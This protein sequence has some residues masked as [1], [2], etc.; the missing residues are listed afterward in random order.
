MGE[1]KTTRRK[2]GRRDFLKS[3]VGVLALPHVVPASAAGRAGHVPPSE[4]V[5][6][7]FIGVGGRGTSELKAFIRNSD[8]QILAV[9]DPF[10]DRRE[11][12][13]SLVESYCDE[14][15]SQ[16]G[17]YKGCAA[18]NDFRDVL[19]RNDIDAVDIATQD[20]WHIP[21]AIAAVRAKKHLQIAKP[22]WLCIAEQRKLCEAVNENDV[23][24]QFGT[25]QRHGWTFKQAVELVHSE[26]IGKLHT[27][28]VGS[29]AG[30]ELENQPTMSIP[31]GFD[32]DLWLGPAPFK[33]YTEKRCIIPWWYHISDYT[34]S[35]FVAGWG[36]HHLDIAQWGNKADR[37]GP[38][39]I[40]GTGIFPKRGICDTALAWDL[41]LKYANGVELIYTDERTDQ[42]NRSSPDREKCERGVL[43][44]GTEGWVFVNR[45]RI[46]A[47]PTNLLG[48]RKKEWNIPY[49]PQEGIRNLLDC[50][51]T[52]RKAICDV[53]TAHRTT[54]VCHLS[55]ICLLLGRKLK[56]DPKIEQFI[57][58]EEANKLLHRT[59]RSPWTL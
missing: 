54:T 7:A 16:K 1:S 3:A 9:C 10:P 59:M 38:V 8:V 30:V 50:I 35:G 22:L 11:E 58:D 43:F 14:N 31:E 45:S 57:D 23:V 47:Q 44:E 40:E 26:R 18:Y 13:K 5:T 52:R 55:R 48:Y 49:V 27:I 56:W 6:M 25:Q 53:E 24:F 41:R 20:S 51:K 36:V 33:P 28:K 29:P 4:R 37:T 46:E 42:P 32:Y 15:L 39:E 12:V 17:S 2:R 34:F 21:Q 19:A